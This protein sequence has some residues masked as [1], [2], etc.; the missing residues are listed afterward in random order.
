[1]KNCSVYFKDGNWSDA[2]IEIND[3]SFAILFADRVMLERPD[4]VQA[5]IKKFPRTR[6]ISCSSAGEILGKSVKDSSVIATIVDFEKTTFSFVTGNIRDYKNSVELGKDLASR[7]DQNG[8]KYVMVISDGNLVNGDAMV[9][10]LHMVLSRNIVVSGGLAGD[11]AR[12]QKTLVGLDNQIEEGN[13]VLLGLYGNHLRISTGVSGGWDPFGPERTITKSKGSM[14]MEID[15]SNALELY[16]KYLGKYADELP[17]SALLFPMSVQMGDNDAYIVRTILSIDEDKGTMKF[18]GTMP[19]GAKVRFMKSNPDRL[20]DAAVTAGAQATE[21]IKK[22]DCSL[23]L[24]VSCVGRKL[25]LADRI[26]EEVE[27]VTEELLPHTSVTGFFSYG[28]IAPQEN[29]D[30]SQLHNQTITVTLFSE[31]P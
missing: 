21:R 10:G 17:A 8:L 3:S 25:V 6:L 7:L 5:F 16:K 28:E 11:A 18:A 29:S 2:N 26:E 23:A 4:P 31:T 30:R 24:I 20:I 27:A 12:F 15:G 22:E 13:V 1:M 9:D 19:E 14:L